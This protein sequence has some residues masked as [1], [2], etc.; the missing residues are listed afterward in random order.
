MVRLPFHRAPSYSPSMSELDQM[1]TNLLDEASLNAI[2][3]GRPDVA[4]YLRLKLANDTIRRIG[5]DWL[6]DTSIDLAIELQQTYNNL[7]I[8]RVSPHSFTKGAS[9]MIGSLVRFQYGVRCFSVEAGWA[10]TPSDGIMRNGALAQSYLKHFGITS[11]NADYRLVRGENLPVW[12]DDS[13]GEI[14]TAILRKHFA[15]LLDN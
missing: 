1:W 13:G 14:T 7:N 12:R 4:E 11:E 6:F 2:N 15:T 3:T 8:E 9:K 10:R 5:V